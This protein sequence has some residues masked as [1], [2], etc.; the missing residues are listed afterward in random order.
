[1]PG[2]PEFRQPWITISSVTRDHRVQPVL[3]GNPVTPAS[4]TQTKEYGA[5]VHLASIEP[6]MRQP[7]RHA[8]AG[9][10]SHIQVA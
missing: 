6:G 5:V 1:M 10:R 7:V 8:D 9:S 3:T 2:V 4:T